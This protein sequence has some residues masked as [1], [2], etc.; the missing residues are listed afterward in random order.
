[1]TLNVDALQIWWDDRKEVY[2]SIKKLVIN[3]DNGPSIASGR[4]QFM[5]RMTEFAEANGLTIHL[6]YYPPYH[7][8]YNPIERCW[9]I[10]E[11]HWNGTILDSLDKALEWIKTMTWKG[12]RPIVHFLEKTY[13]KGVCLTKK[14]MK[15]YNEKIERSSAL[16]KW[17]VVIEGTSG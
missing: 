17:D 10:L 8:K 12:I 11:T 3:L 14:E 4:T 15:K 7:S 5:K 1:M 2:P 13:E 6:V 16:P 9:G